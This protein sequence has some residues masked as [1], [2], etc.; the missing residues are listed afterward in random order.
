MTFIYNL[1]LIN[2]LLIMKK[3]KKKKKKKK[4]KKLKILFIQKNIIYSLYK[5]KLALLLI[6]K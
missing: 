1:N 3:K 4:E 6:V 2:L 5:I